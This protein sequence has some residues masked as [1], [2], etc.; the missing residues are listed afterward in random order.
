MLEEYSLLG[1][2]FLIVFA[3]QQPQESACP[4]RLLTSDYSPLKEA[5]YYLKATI[6]IKSP[7]EFKFSAMRLSHREKKPDKPAGRHSSLEFCSI[8]FMQVRSC[9]SMK[10]IL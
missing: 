8:P 1:H 2:Y 9:G 6:W 5:N 4:G 7:K 3:S 10:M